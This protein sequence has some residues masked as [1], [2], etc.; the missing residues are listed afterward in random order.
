MKVPE[1]EIKNKEKPNRKNPSG[2]NPIVE[3]YFKKINSATE[4][5]KPTT[6]IPYDPNDKWKWEGDVGRSLYV[7]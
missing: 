7:L 4:A 3:E 5:A 1:K 6:Q 2:K